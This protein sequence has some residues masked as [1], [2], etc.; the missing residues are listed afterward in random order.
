MLSVG[1]NITDNKNNV[2]SLLWLSVFDSLPI[3]ASSGKF[4][5]EN[6]WLNLESVPKKEDALN[7]KM[8]RAMAIIFFLRNNY[9]THFFESDRQIT[10]KKKL[11][12]AKVV[13]ENDN[14]S[15]E[16]EDDSYDKDEDYYDEDYY[17]EPYFPF[18]NFKQIEESTIAYNFIKPKS[19]FE[20]LHK[21]LKQYFQIIYYH[22]D[23]D[24]TYHKDKIRNEIY[25]GAN[26]K[27]NA[28]CRKLKFSELFSLEKLKTVRDFIKNNG[29]FELLR[30]VEKGAASKEYDSSGYYCN[31]QN[32]Y[33][34]NANVYHGF[35]HID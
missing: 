15:S 10:Q 1:E 20:Y 31:E 4:Y 12:E 30:C 25:H 9:Y 35:L 3:Y 21:V 33:I 29:I 18:K 17:G 26:E 24:N 7:V 16:E 2:H 32:Y 19:D 28:V 5:H 14:N 22:Y 11:K 13:D 6:A 27:F 34:E 8:L 23:N